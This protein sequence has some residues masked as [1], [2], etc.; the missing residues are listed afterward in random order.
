MALPASSSALIA[1]TI[2]ILRMAITSTVK[3][4]GNGEAVTTPVCRFSAA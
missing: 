2:N 3:L 1:T 4:Q